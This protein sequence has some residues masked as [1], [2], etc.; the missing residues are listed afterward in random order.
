MK[1]S[2]IARALLVLA[3]LIALGGAA[4][5][6][7]T[8]AHRGWSQTSV[9]TMQLD[10]ITGIETPVYEDRFVAGVD[11]LGITLLGAGA[12]AAGSLFFRKTKNN[13]T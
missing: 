5:W 9:Q 13:N 4:V 10:E 1:R 3:L 6:L 8:G 11:F 2:K 12:L 7:A